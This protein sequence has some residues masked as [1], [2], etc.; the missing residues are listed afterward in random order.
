MANLG[1]VFLGEN[2]NT[3][4]RIPGHPPV[5]IQ[6]DFLRQYGGPRHLFSVIIE[7]FS[8]TC[9]HFKMTPLVCQGDYVWRRGVTV[10]KV[11]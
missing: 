9:N 2:H 5:C 7:L 10:D 11:Y 3:A 6:D 4:P 1:Q 8:Q